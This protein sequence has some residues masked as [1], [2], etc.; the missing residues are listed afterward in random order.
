MLQ[1]RAEIVVLRLQ[2]RHPL[3]LV[4]SAQVWLRLFGELPIEAEV[5][6]RH[7]LRLAALRQLTLRVLANHLQQAVPARSGAVLLKHNERFA[8]QGREEVRN[9]P[10]LEG[11]CGRIRCRPAGPV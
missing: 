4:R 6:R 9:L 11:R 8:D 1:R 7:R 5:S 3:R 10:L 2:A